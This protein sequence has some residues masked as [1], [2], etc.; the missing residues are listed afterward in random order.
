VLTREDI[1][2]EARARFDADMSFEDATRDIALDDYRSWGDAERIAVNCATL[3]KEYRSTVE[4]DM[5]AVYALM[6]KLFVDNTRG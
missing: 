1:P 3:Y 4:I 5:T 6:A 2:K